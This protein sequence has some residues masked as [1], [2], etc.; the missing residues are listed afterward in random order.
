MEKFVNFDTT[1]IWKC[2]CKSWK[3]MVKYGCQ[4]NS[5]E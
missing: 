5:Q 2:Y 4:I 1:K 3:D